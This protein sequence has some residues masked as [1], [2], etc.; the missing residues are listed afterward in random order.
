V[1][2]G[3]ALFRPLCQCAVRDSASMLVKVVPGTRRSHPADPYP[4]CHPSPTPPVP[5][6]NTAALPPAF[7]RTAKDPAHS[8]I[9]PVALSACDGSGWKSVMAA[10]PPLSQAANM[11]HLLALWPLLCST[12]LIV[13]Q[14]CSVECSPAKGGHL[15]IRGRTRGWLIIVFLIALSKN[16]NRWG[17]NIYQ[18]LL[19]RS[20]VLLKK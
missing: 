6:Y 13:I 8:P 14:S 17:P 16:C 18:Q 4:T 15:G 20:N 3:P 12:V 2:R 19:G 1:S 9:V 11:K 10:P 7:L 5:P